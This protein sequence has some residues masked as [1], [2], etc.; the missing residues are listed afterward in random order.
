MD[1]LRRDCY[2]CCWNNLP[3]PLRRVRSVSTFKRQL[4]TFPS[5]FSLPR[6]CSFFIFQ[7]LF[8][9]A[10]CH[11]RP[12]CISL[13]YVAVIILTFWFYFDLPYVGRHRRR[14]LW[15]VWRPRLSSPTQQWPS[16]PRHQLRLLRCQASTKCS[17][18]DNTSCRR[19]P[20]WCLRWPLRPAALP[21]VPCS[22]PTSVATIRRRSVLLPWPP[23]RRCVCPEWSTR[24]RDPQRSCRQWPTASSGL[25]CYCC[26][27]S[28]E[29]VRQI[30]IKLKRNWND[31]ETKQ[32]DCLKLFCCSFVSVSFEFYFSFISTVR[33]V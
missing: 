8:S 20:T 2:A 16:H 21:R 6:R 31:T 4:N 5:H 25:P 28:Y 18:N 26:P 10:Y 17:R 19:L 22:C 23:V 7:L 27:P 11:G 3:S 24:P 33:A 13:T 30:E 1:N 32:F 29:T 15:A 14:D 9:T 12:C